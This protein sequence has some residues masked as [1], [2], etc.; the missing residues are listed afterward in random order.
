MPAGLAVG[1]PATQKPVPLVAPWALEQTC[2]MSL[3][4]SEGKSSPATTWA[5]PTTPQPTPWMRYL[6]PISGLQFTHLQSGDYRV[7]TSQGD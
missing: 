5:G 7:A 3:P 1:A 2:Q 6:T 4:C